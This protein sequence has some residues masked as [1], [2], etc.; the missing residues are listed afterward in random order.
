MGN[1]DLTELKTALNSK[2]KQ[3]R[4]KAIQA[5]EAFNLGAKESSGITNNHVHSAYS[6]SPYMPARIVYEAYQNDL[7]IVGIMDH[8]SISGAKEFIAAGKAFGVATTIGFEVRTDWSDTPFKD[9]RLNNPDQI[10]CAYMCVHGVPH[11]NISK[12]SAF[13]SGIV[14]ARNERNRKMV[15]KINQ[16]VPDTPISF[17][18]DVVPLSRLSEGGSI[19]ERHILFALAGKMVEKQGKGEALIAYL[20]NQCGI[21]LSNSQQ[22]M[23]MDTDYE[24]YLYDVLNI[25]KGNFVSKI[26]I[27]AMP[28]E[29]T[30]IRD[31]VAFCREIGAVLSY[32]YLGD[33]TASP[34]GDKKAQVFE[35]EY[36]DAL[37]AYLTELNVNAVAYMPSR[38]TAEQMNRV[39]SLCEKFGLF[40]IS[41]EDINQPR[42]P[43]VCK[44]LSEPAFLHLGQAAWA[45]VGHEKKATLDVERGM[46]SA[47]QKERP[48]QERTQEFAA[49]GRSEE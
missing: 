8:D 22:D 13:L 32:A 33:V 14:K 49:F 26:F 25:L 6:F 31:L 38:N 48:L 43:F 45:L 20:Q 10:G 11:Q 23:L 27:P 19:T 47:I 1:Q 46:F 2:N 16:V 39:I 12:V 44:Q 3:T 28:P 17:D 37:F 30:P 4:L 42:Q 21:V 7:D 18:E 40:Q 29:T 5:V 36:L 15:A 24:Y 35:D 41:G 9:K 34:T